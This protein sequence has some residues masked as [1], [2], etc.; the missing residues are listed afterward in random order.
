MTEYWIKIY[1]HPQGV[2]H[3]VEGRWRPLGVTIDDEID[4]YSAIVTC[5]KCNTQLRLH[6]THEIKEDGRVY[7]TVLCGCGFAEL[8]K[9]EGWGQ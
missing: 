7:P 5:P 4:H 2:D 1:P 9:L 3:L 6:P 8:I